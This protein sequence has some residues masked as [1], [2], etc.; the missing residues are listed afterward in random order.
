MSSSRAK[1]LVVDGPNTASA[2]RGH[3]QPQLGDAQVYPLSG[4]QVGG[5]IHRGVDRSLDVV[6]EVRRT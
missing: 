4:V 1:P 2:A 6:E 3:S 5:W